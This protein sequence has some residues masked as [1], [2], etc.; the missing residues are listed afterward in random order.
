MDRLT[1]KSPCGEYQIDDYK[2]INVTTY[3]DENFKNGFDVY[4][5]AAIDKLGRYEDTG[6]TPEEFKESVD[7]ILELNAKVRDM[8]MHYESGF[9]NG[10][11]KFVNY[12][13]THLC[14]YDLD[15]YHSFDAIDIEDLDDLVEEFLDKKEYF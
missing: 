15:N 8:T 3:F 1:W 10:V 12:L 9:K 2:A 5:G 7:F 6:L 11:I 4:E 14:S 13:K